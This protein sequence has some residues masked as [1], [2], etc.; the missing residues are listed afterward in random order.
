[1]IRSNTDEYDERRH[2]SVGENREA[3]GVSGSGG[4]VEN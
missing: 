2:G 4:K 1:M 3:P